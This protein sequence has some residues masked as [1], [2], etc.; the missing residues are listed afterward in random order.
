[1]KSIKIPMPEQRRSPRI[2]RFGWIDH[3]FLSDGVLAQLS[4]EALRLYVFLVLVANKDG[5]SWYSYDRICV[6]LQIDM[7]TYM[8]ARNEL[9]EHFLIA[10]EQDVFQVLLMPARKQPEPPKSQ[11]TGQAFCRGEDFRTLKELL[12]QTQKVKS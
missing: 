6:R 4:G 3:R 1:M 7:N 5:V 11:A 2:C 8:A 12:E 9:L 10:Y